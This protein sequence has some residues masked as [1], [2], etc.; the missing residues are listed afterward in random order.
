VTTAVE[1]VVGQEIESGLHVWR[2]RVWLFW[3][4][5]HR[6][7][8]SEPRAADGRSAMVKANHSR[9]FECNNQV[10]VAAA[11]AAASAAVI[12]VPDLHRG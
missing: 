8:M 10:F 2:R 6:K 5:A 3:L 12:L 7:A 9:S 4:V 1:A 11:A